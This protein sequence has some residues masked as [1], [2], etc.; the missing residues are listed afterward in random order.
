MNH[1]SEKNMDRNHLGNT[2]F[3]VFLKLDQCLTLIVG[4]GA[5]GAEKLGAVLKNSP[6][7]QV[8]LVA[9][10]IG[11]EVRALAKGHTVTLLEEPFNNTH[12]EGV[13]LVIV[14]T[15]NRAFNAA[16]ATAAKAH[17]ILVNVADTPVQCDFYLSATVQKGDLKIAISTNGK[18][19]TLAKRFRE[20]FETALPNNT[21]DLLNNLHQIRHNITGDFKAKVQRMNKVT[22]SMVAENA[23]NATET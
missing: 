15:G 13:Q 1:E 23:T 4:G 17:N 18:S 14:G 3:P 11:N 8:R 2:L 12:L 5:I 6:N 10:T 16:V 7:A 19:P 21:Q 22:A 20:Y 9:T